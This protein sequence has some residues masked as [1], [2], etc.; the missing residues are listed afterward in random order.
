MRLALGHQRS[1]WVS[2]VG[3]R[4][5]VVAREE[6]VRVLTRCRVTMQLYIEVKI[7]NPKNI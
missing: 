6:V 3:V 2:H 5:V 1:D 4:E 7:Y